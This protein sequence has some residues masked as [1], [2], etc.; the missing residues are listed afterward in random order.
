MLHLVQQQIEIVNHVLQ[1]QSGQRQDVQPHS[2][3]VWTE[4]IDNLTG[5]KLYHNSLT[6]VTTFDKPEEMKSTAEKKR[7]AIIS[8]GEDMVETRAGLGSFKQGYDL[9][10]DDDMD[11]KMRVYKVNET[12]GYLD[13]STF[14]SASADKEI[15][16]NNRGFKL[17]VKMGWKRGQGL[18]KGG[19]GITAPVQ[20]RPNE[21]G[22]TLGLGKA[23][24]YEEKV[25]TAAKQRKKLDV[26]VEET[27]EEVT[28][29][30]ADAEKQETIKQDV[31]EMNKEFYCEICDKQYKNVSE[32][33]NHLSSYDHHH[34]K[35]FKEMKAAERARAEASGETEGRRRRE[36]QREARE[37]ERR[38]AAA[39]AA[40]AAAQPT[41]QLATLPQQA[42]VSLSMSGN[43]T[44]A[45]VKG[46][47]AQ[48]DGHHPQQQ[49]KIAFT[50]GG[51]GGGA[52]KSGGALNR[53]INTKKIGFSFGVKK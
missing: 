53:G 29:R 38:L 40:T 33:S 32:M 20:L 48:N 47:S 13:L 35:R 11:D 30:L 25:D 23:G 37:M 5:R 42:A 4:A 51:G 28:K 9:D 49:Q 1:H 27:D 39:A 52:K 10:F 41:Q 2:Q 16:E 31:K 19:K 43:K 18:G 45:G 34:T 21:A 15:P 24:E 3:S 50:F 8:S 12:K 17:L 7:D 46:T 26:E 22:D 6:G 44:D 14:E 36:R